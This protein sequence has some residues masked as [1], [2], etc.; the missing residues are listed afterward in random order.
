M[1]DHERSEAADQPEPDGGAI[2]LAESPMAEHPSESPTPPRLG[3]LGA[4][5]RDPRLAWAVA[6]LA[7]VSAVVLG[8]GARSLR[9][10]EDRRTSAREAAA[11]VAIRLTTFEGATIDQ[12]VADVQQ[13]STPEYAGQL[14]ERFD[15]NLRESLRANDVRSTGEIL[16]T[17]IQRL[18]GEE[19]LAFILIRQT[20]TNAQRPEPIED[21]LR[22]EVTLQDVDGEWL[23]ADVAVLGPSFLAGGEA[24]DVPSPS[25]APSA[26][27]APAGPTAP[28]TTPAG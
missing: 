24:G 25:E 12:W 19:A 8:L 23:A 4:V 3:G 21:E 26:G 2:A 18:Q 14:V 20:S 16:D 15:Q 9:A 11:D 17:Y 28:S 22:M 1:T 27:P 10:M 7:L 6:L 13:L 5:L